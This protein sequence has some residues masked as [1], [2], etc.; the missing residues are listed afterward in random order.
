MSSQ[1]LNVVKMGALAVITAA[2][3][4]SGVLLTREGSSAGIQL[5][6]AGILIVLPGAALASFALGLRVPAASPPRPT[7]R[8]TRKEHAP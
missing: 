7:T 6:V 4:A 3:I 2:S 1:P 5:G 8:P